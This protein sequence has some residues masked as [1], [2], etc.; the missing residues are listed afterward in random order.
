MSIPEPQIDKGKLLA[1][2]ERF[3]S[4]KI[5]VVGDII[6]DQYIWG[7]VSRISPEAPVPVVEVA[8]ETKML[9]GAANVISNLVAL[10]AEPVL[11][12]VIGDDQ[13]GEEILSMMR[14]IGL[15]TDSIL[16]EAGRSTSIKT[17]IIAHNQQVVRFDKESR[18]PIADEVMQQILDIASQAVAETDI[19]LISDYGKG[20][21]SRELVKGLKALTE[22][23]EVPIAVDPKTGNF[24]CYQ[25]V[26]I[27]TPNN[28]EA[29]GYCRFNIEGEETLLKAGEVILQELDCNAVLITQGKDGMTLFERGGT[30][31]HISAVAKEVYDVTGAG[32]TVIATLCLGVAAGLDLVSSSLIANFAGGIVVGKVGTSVVST[33]ELRA[34]IMT[35][36]P[37]L[38]GA[39]S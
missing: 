23:L 24:A 28:D 11:Y 3:S 36:E 30:V 29:S 31:T 7:S 21:V 16:V 4:A 2:L 38:R 15:S 34:A 26:E 39:E 6:L 37:S 12:G 27:I 22:K 1:A 20:V 17:R 18:R 9:G 8:K 35:Y 13:T 5:A 32:D 19:I 33:E 14:D 10:G 25:G